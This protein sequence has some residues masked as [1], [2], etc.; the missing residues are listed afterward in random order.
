VT[1]DR[2]SASEPR[3]DAL[4]DELGDRRTEFLAALADVD[5]VLRTTP[6]LV[7]ALSARDLVVHVAFWSDHAADALVLAAGGRGTEFAYDASQT[8]AMNARVFADGRELSMDEAMGRDQAAYGRFREALA[9]ITDGLLDLRL[10]NG[11]TVEGV[12]RYDGA[13]HFAEHAGQVRAWFS[14]AEESEDDE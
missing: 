7:D 14:G 9:G 8:D 11:D 6:G 3:R 13:D 12:I 4:L 10:G 1:A 5:P 2:V